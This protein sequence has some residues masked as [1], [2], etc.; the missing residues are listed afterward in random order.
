MFSFL[1]IYYA[2]K[3]YYNHSYLNTI[4]LAIFI[5]LAM[6]TKLSG[7]TICI[8]IAIIFILEFIKSIKTKNKPIN[9]CIKY[10]VFLL[11]CA[12]LGLW[13]Q[14]YAKIRFNQP[15]GYVLGQDGVGIDP[16]LSTADHN[17]FERI[18][19]FINFD[20]IFGKIYLNSRENYSLLNYCLKSAIF[21]EFSYWQGESFAVL[22]IFF[23][24]MF[25]FSS[26]ILFIIYAI[27]AKKEDFFAKLMGFSIIISQAACMIYFYIRMPYG[28]TM[29]FRYI[30]PII[31]GFAILMGLCYNKFKEEN[32]KR[33]TLLQFTT[34]MMLGFLLFS[35]IFYLVCI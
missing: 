20:E 7:A 29:D 3:W 27:K 19:L 4:L 25:F 16:R 32:S 12:S 30:V 8:P 10:A 11:I 23:N 14:I 31:I 5:G 2:I 17:I 34:A 24:Y 21:G 33:K 13:F 6:M 22:S 35:N 28:C 26:I 15:F 9:L 18:F 1:A